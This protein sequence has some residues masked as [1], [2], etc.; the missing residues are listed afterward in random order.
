MLSVFNVL[1]LKCKLKIKMPFLPFS[2]MT[3]HYLS[4]SWISKLGFLALNSQIGLLIGNSLLQ[5]QTLQRITSEQLKQRVFFS[6]AVIILMYLLGLYSLND[7]I[8][9]CLL[10]H[11]SCV[12]LF[13]T[14]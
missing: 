8:C 2:F 11:F 10:S 4:G 6:R 3:N 1:L 14:L 13:A 7:E 12:Q 5:N 9:L